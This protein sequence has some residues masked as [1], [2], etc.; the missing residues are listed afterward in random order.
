MDGWTLD[1]ID[2]PLE[3]SETSELVES[4]LVRITGDASRYSVG[5]EPWLARELGK[6]QAITVYG[7]MCD[8]AVLLEALQRLPAGAPAADVDAEIQQATKAIWP[9]HLWREPISRTEI[10]PAT[11]RRSYSKED[12]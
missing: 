4:E 5:Y 2:E 3:R 8:G 7:Q 10:D 9:P 12:E 11:G 1:T 6:A